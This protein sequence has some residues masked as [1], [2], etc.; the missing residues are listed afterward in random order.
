MSAK[1]GIT[2]VVLALLSDNIV[3]TSAV[4]HSA[5]VS[6]I[7]QLCHISGVAV[8]FLC[9]PFTMFIRHSQCVYAIGLLYLLYRR[10]M[11]IR[12]QAIFILSLHY[13]SRC[14]NI[15]PDTCSIFHFVM[16]CLVAHRQEV[17]DRNRKYR[18]QNDKREETKRE[19]AVVQ[20][21]LQYTQ[22]AE[23]DRLI[24]TLQSL[25]LQGQQ[26]LTEQLCV[27]VQGGLPCLHPG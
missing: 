18:V 23:R 6:F 21:A 26:R 15:L 3:S 16:T 4:F 13:M 25:L 14:R 2:L 22:L 8:R 24:A 12:R 20:Q 7:Q 9:Y 19:R 17:V 10:T 1:C 27:D 11:I 5:N